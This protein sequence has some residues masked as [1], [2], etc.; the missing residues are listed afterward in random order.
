MTTLDYVK[1]TL[2]ERRDL[3]RKFANEE[4]YLFKKR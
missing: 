2:K 4:K 1:Q 3:F